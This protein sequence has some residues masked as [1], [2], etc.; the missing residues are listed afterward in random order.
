MPRFINPGTGD[1]C[2]ISAGTLA[3][4]PQ[5]YIDNM[6]AVFVDPDGNRW[7]SNGLSLIPFGGIDDVPVSQAPIPI[8]KYGETT[9]VGAIGDS[10]VVG[11]GVISLFTSIPYLTE[12][13]WRAGTNAGVAGN[14]S[15]QMLAR[16][17]SVPVTNYGMMIFESA[18]D[19]GTGVTVVQHLS[20]MF[21]IALLYQNRQQVPILVL[22]TPRTG[23]AT[24]ISKYRI[25]EVLKCLQLKY[26]C[27]DFWRE[28]FDEST[29]EYVAGKTSDGV[30][31]TDVA[32]VDQSILGG[33]RVVANEQSSLRPVYNGE[34]AS[35]FQN[36]LMLLDSNADNVPNNWSLIGGTP[37]IPEISSAVGDGLRG[38]WFALTSAGMFSYAEYGL[39]A[40]GNFSIGDEL[41]FVCAIKYVAISSNSQAQFNIRMN[42][43]QNYILTGSSAMRISADVMFIVQRII[44]LTLDT[45]QAQLQVLG[46]DVG[47]KIYL[48]EFAVYNQTKLFTNS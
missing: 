8:N 22:G 26:P 40:S 18:N 34:G 46:S 7:V 42:G 33:A 13:L 30:H 25:S 48:G 9:V 47:Q 6:A 4:P 29:G 12:G 38:N 17:L 45:I 14:T 11:P 24:I 37:A 23:F 36:C 35:L 5:E 16:C 39:A 44:V 32:I 10:I 41:V 2:F 31:P 15:A 27:F 43:G 21:G 3:N 1:A 20:N 28:L 19:A